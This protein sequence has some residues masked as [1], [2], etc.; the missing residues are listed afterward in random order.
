MTTVE[1]LRAGDRTS[2]TR[3]PRPTASPGVAFRRSKACGPADRAPGRGNQTSSG[4]GN[5]NWL[6][7]VASLILA[8]DLTESPCRLRE[9]KRAQ[10]CPRLREGRA[11]RPPRTRGLIGKRKN[12]RWATSAG[13]GRSTRSKCHADTPPRP[14]RK[15]K[16]ARAGYPGDRVDTMPRPCTC[17]PYGSKRPAESA[18]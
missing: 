6:R 18:P 17:A 14:K 9:V 5:L 3:S 7:E 13:C 4:K 15:P 8:L 11:P 2:R 12:L 1:S 10:V 16:A